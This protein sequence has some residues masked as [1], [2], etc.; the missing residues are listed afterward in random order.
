MRVIVATK[1]A[2]KLNEIKSL[3]SALDI[4]V[5]DLKTIGFD[6]E[7]EENGQTFAENAMIKASAIAAYYPNDLIL[8]DDSGLCVDVLGGMPGIY[9]ARF[10]E[11][12]TDYPKKFRLLWSMLQD[13]PESDWTARFVC[14]M[15]VITPD[16]G[17]S[18]FAS[19]WSGHLLNSPRGDHGFGYDPIFKPDGEI[20]S[21][22]EMSLEKKN[23]SS[24]RAQTL[25]KVLNH[26]TTLYGTTAD[27]N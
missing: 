27:E 22:A 9:S 3:L 17:R 7:I 21:A 24:H 6:Q 15:A 2:G 25:Q 8:A 16:H 5:V 12:T 18:I 19:Q 23:K 14:A 4:E 20:I 11:T 13:V 1:N 26:L 10:A